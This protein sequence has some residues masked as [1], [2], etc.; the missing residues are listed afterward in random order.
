MNI[1]LHV[2][3]PKVA[4]TWFKKKF[5]P[6]VKNIKVYDRA[7]VRECFHEPGAFDFDADLVRKKLEPIDVRDI[8][9]SE[10]L[11]T[12]RSWTGGVQ[13][14]VTKEVAN[15]LHEVFPQAN[16]IIFIRNQIDILASFYLQ[17]IKSGGNYNIQ[18]FLYPGKYLVGGANRLVISPD[19]FLYDKVIKYYCDLF[20][21]NKVHIFVFEEFKENPKEFI[22][23]FSST[24]GLKLNINEIDFSAAN[25]GY[26]R[27]ILP[28]RKFTNIFSRNGPFN[29]YYLIHI[30]KIN[31]LC[32]SYLEKAN[33]FRIFGIRLNSVKIL[34]EKNTAYFKKYYAKSNQILIKEYGLNTIRKH[35]YPLP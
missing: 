8:W 29:K 5:L 16:I 24:F 12:D 20:G 19:F 18:K 2:G 6:H 31:Y 28:V 17:Y 7:I 21:R 4:S 1:Y 34:G 13:G 32:K 23:Q 27:F 15:R 26:R 30:P 33:Q 3:Y 11:L 35:N 9:I 10:E 22:S 14:F 25:M